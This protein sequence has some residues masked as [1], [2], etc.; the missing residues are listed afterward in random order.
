MNNFT[1]SLVLAA[2][3]TAGDASAQRVKDAKVTIE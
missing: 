3:V 2:V 1:R